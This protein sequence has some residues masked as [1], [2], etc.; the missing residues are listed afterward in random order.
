VPEDENYVPGFIGLRPLYD[1][2]QYYTVSSSER[3]RYDVQVHHADGSVAKLFGRV[4]EERKNELVRAFAGG[5][6]P[7]GG[8]S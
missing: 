6:L 5:G 4:D 8:Q 7:E 3:N 1:E 2:G